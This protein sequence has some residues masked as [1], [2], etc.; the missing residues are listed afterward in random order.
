MVLGKPEE[1]ADDAAGEPAAARTASPEAAQKPSDGGA[2]PNFS[3]GSFFASTSERAEL[4]QF[5]VYVRQRLAE[6]EQ[7]MPPRL[8]TRERAE[9]AFLEEQVIEDHMNKR[10]RSLRDP[11]HDT[12]EGEINHTNLNLLSRFVSEAGA[13]LPR[14][15]TGVNGRKQRRIAKSL[16][17]AHML[18]LL[19]RTWKHPKYRHA[20]YADQYSKPEMAVQPR[21][22]L[23]EFRDPPDIRFPNRDRNRGALK[24]DVSRLA[25]TS[26]GL[27]A[28]A[29]SS[30]GRG[31]S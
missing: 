24:V 12:P 29:P 3:T 23:D 8:S 4:L 18:A 31:R 11:L 1:A 22:E 10:R 6:L 28:L 15:L 2:S 20:S 5:Q 21:A 19:P 17:R 26:P 27:Q 16:K 14:K 25:R 13:I 7:R 30:L 9:L